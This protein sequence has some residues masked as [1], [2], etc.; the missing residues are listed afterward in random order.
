MAQLPYEQQIPTRFVV[1]NDVVPNL[2]GV[3]DTWQD[4][5]ETA[6][7]MG[8]A[9]T[10][11]TVILSN[12]P[13]AALVYTALMTYPDQWD[14]LFSEAFVAML[15]SRLAMTLVPDP[16]A[17]VA[18]RDEQI[19]V[20]KDALTQARISD[21]D[22]GWFTTDHIPDWLRVRSAGGAWGSGSWAGDGGLGVLFNGW[23]ACSFGDGS[24]Y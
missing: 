12:Q 6:Q 1:S 9:L 10:N 7:T 24:A 15:A 11:Q 2:I 8:Q 20:A 13:N 14:P 19:K 18:I 16:R 22:E 4:V 3:P 5:P 17:R 23:S 21:G